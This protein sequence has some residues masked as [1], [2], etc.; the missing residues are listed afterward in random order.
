MIDFIINNLGYLIGL[1]G[2]LLTIYSIKKMRKVKQ[3]SYQTK[4]FKLIDNDISSIDG[5][6]VSYNNGR[7]NNLTVSK[8]YIWNSGNTII[9]QNDIASSNKLHIEYPENTSILNYKINAVSSETCQFK[10][11][12]PTIHGSVLN[13]DFEYMERKQGVVINVLHTDNEDVKDNKGEDEE[14]DEDE[15]IKVFGT[16]KEGK[17]I[18][19]TNKKVNDWVDSAFEGLIPSLFLILTISTVVTIF[20]KISWSTWLEWTLGITLILLIM[21]LFIYLLEIVKKMILKQMFGKLNKEYQK[22]F[23]NRNF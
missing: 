2:V 6:E 21:A 15:E 9:N 20:S 22:E 8:V 14:V 4:S 23:S 3:L 10:V 19:R 5:F 16:V 7:I 1:F 17:I 12:P 13:I 18:N 11:T